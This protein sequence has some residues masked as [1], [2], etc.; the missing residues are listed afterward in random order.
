MFVPV[1]LTGFGE[2]E[3][4]TP[5]GNPAMERL[6]EPANALTE[7][8]GTDTAVVAPGARFTLPGF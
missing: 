8:T 2:K 1:R 6:T 7:I 4:V 5:V 3:A